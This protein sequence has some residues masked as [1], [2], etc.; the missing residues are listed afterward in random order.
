MRYKKVSIMFSLLLCLALLVLAGCDTG[1]RRTNMS[2]PLTSTNR[3]W[4]LIWSST[5]AQQSPSPEAA[6]AA[7][8]QAQSP[9]GSLAKPASTM[10]LASTSNFALVLVHLD[11]A[12]QYVGVGMM[13]IDP[14][15]HQWIIE[16]SFSIGRPL[17]GN[18]I[19]APQ[20][21]SGWTLPVGTYMSVGSNIAS[22]TPQG[23]IRLWVSDSQQE[24]VLAHVYISVK[25][26]STK[27][28]N[29]VINGRHGWALTQAGI[30]KIV[31]EMDQGT[32]IFAGTTPL[33]QSQQMVTQALAHL[34]NLLFSF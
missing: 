26:P 17:S 33:L 1:N 13:S 30:T 7:C 24:F 11:P 27:T 31:L 22:T 28:T 34:S 32:L 10:W 8:A 14:I 2:P 6:F 12:G 18:G 5:N 3:S 15:H 21:D 23:S 16:Q 4:T 9:D 29:I 19:S 20:Q 25:R